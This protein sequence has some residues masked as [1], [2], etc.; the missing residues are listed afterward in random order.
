MPWAI[1][2]PLLPDESLSSWLARAALLQ[3][4]DPLALTGAVWPKWRAWT[5]DIDRELLADRLRLLTSA[6]GI[7]PAS[8]VRAFLRADAETVAGRVLA[9]AE[10]WPWLLALGSRN[11]RRHGGQQFCPACLTEDARPYFRRH[12]RFA[13]H[14]ACAQHR[15]LLVDGCGDCGEPIAFHRLL[16]EDRHLALCSRCHWDLRRTACAPASAESLTFQSMADDALAFGSG[17]IWGR[18]VTAAE[19]FVAARFF[20]GAIRRTA[21]R[22]A[23][24]LAGAIRSLGVNLPEQVV[25]VTGL[26]L[27]MS[28]A[29]D[30]HVLLHAAFHLMQAG[31][32][33][34]AAALGENGVAAAT[35]HGDAKCLPEPVRAIAASLPRGRGTAKR[36]ARRARAAPRSEA[37]VCGA[38]ARLQRRAKAGEP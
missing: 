12:W 6:S 4:C 29:L 5:V 22:R 14:V 31:P 24:K 11:R 9:D 21:R 2:V 34:W 17:A 19:W 8:F 32:L 37:A 33:A 35:L 28:S 23:S 38:W 15:S 36:Q 1:P 13:W 20:V 18:R 16:A 7:R 10:T 25:P 26:P 30:R 3:G 27:E